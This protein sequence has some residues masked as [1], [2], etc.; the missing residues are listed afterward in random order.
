MGCIIRPAQSGKALCS[1]GLERAYV[2][3]FAQAQ[4]DA[5]QQE[6]LLSWCLDVAQRRVDAIVGS[7]HRRSYDKAAVLT[8]ACAEVLRLRGDKAASEALVSDM[9]ARF[10]RHRAFQSEMESVLRRMEHGSR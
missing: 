7:Q 2:E 4:V 9:R 8:A 5:R 1:N 6:K 3:R 10:P